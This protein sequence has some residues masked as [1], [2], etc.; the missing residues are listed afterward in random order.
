MDSNADAFGGW[1]MVRSESLTPEALLA[2]LKAGAFCASQGPELQS[3]AVDD[4]TLA[5]TSSAV[6]R[7]TVLGPRALATTVSGRSMTA[8]RIAILRYAGELA[9]RGDR[10]GRAARLDQPL[11]RPG[12]TMAGRGLRGR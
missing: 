11:P 12:L 10:R 2:A 4:G 8:A 1:V 3:V 7:I 5:V 9:P 6:G